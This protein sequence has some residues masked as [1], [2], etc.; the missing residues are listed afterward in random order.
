MVLY[1]LSMYVAY[2]CGTQFVS[3]EMTVTSIHAVGL[4]VHDV[5]LQA[6]YSFIHKLN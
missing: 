6:L 5:F 1:V 4:L 3:S 2:L